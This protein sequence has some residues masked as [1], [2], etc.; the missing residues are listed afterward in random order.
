MGRAITIETRVAARAQGG[1]GDKIGAAVARSQNV[2]NGAQ[3]GASEKVHTESLVH[4]KMM[5]N[6]VTESLPLRTK[7]SV[8]DIPR[9][10]SLGQRS[11]GSDRSDPE[12][13]EASV[14]IVSRLTSAPDYG[15][16]ARENQ[17]VFATRRDWE[18]SAISKEASAI[19]REAASVPV[20]R[21]SAGEKGGEEPKRRS[22]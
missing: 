9:V 1:G 21:V 17:R 8:L 4:N 20:G 7:P 19:S 11:A 2:Q 15:R 16:P 10:R 18:A 6:A 12:L 13:F 22:S 5:A 3:N 14:M